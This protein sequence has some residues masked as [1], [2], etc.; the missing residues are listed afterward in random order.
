MLSPETIDKI[1]DL[2]RLELVTTG[3]GRVFSTHHLTEIVS[4]VATPL[5][6]H[7]L[8]GIVDYLKKGLDKIEDPFAVHVVSHD[9]VR[10]IS[11]NNVDYNRGV[12]AEAEMDFNG[13][14]FD[15]WMDHESFMIAL[16]SLFVKTPSR[17][18]ILRIAGTISADEIS[19]IIDDG[20]TQE[21]TA[22]AGIALKDKVE[23]PNPVTLRPYRTFRE[24]PQPE[25]AF[26]FRVRKG[27]SDGL[28]LVLFEADGE[29]W[30]LEAIG[31]VATWLRGELPEVNVL[32]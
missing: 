11:G 19:V 23:L 27:G 5:T 16:Q 20:V 7:T 25:S 31:N 28:G 4:P 1:I 21:V 18:E 17:D 6:F 22:R 26:V 2:Q 24:V 29:M 10:V 13:F 30:R 14:D 9:L 12:F 15:A 32:A 3:D 8:T